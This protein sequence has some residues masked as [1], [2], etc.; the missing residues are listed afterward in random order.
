MSLKK[1]ILEPVYKKIV[2]TLECESTDLQTVRLDAKA[3]YQLS[4]KHDLAHLIGDIL[5]KNALLSIES[6]IKKR[7]IQ[8]RNMAIYRYEQIN[9]ELEE[10]CRILEENEIPHIPLKGSVLRRYYPEPWM[11]TSCDIDILIKKED[12]ETAI[13]ALKK[14]GFQY[15]ETQTHDAQMWAPSGVHFELHFDLIESDVAEKSAMVLAQ[16]WER[17][18]PCDGWKYRLEFDDAFFY[19]YH[20]AH[21]AKHFLIGGCGIRPFLDIWILKQYD[22]FCGE[23]I[24]ALLRRADL[25][26]F[27]Q[28]AEKLSKVWFGDASHNAVTKEMEEYIVQAG[29]YGSLDNRIALK[30]AKI[31]GKKKHLLSRIFMP[32]AQLKTYYPKLEKYPIL[33]P[34]YQVVR[35]FRIVFGKH[36][37][38]AF[39]EL[40]SIATTKDERKERLITLCNNLGIKK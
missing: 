34:F 1:N 33:Y 17:T 26:T 7:F 25:L 32:Y 6:E 24:A 22:S 2:G 27:A 36:N 23:E 38:H 9:Y 30:Q 40:K 18:K 35:W 29:V 37:K 11:R 10:S 5:H 39:R 21:M 8:E 31:G 28:H 14:E 4:K 16:A 19:F 3:L 15:E 13:Q 20:I 12:L